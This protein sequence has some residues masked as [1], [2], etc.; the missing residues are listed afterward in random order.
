MSDQKNLIIAIALS[1]AIMLGFQFFVDAP[2][3]ERMRAEQA[4]QKA[5]T[6]QVTTPDG[7]SAPTAAGQVPGQAPGLSAMPSV[8]GAPVVPGAA[9][10]AVVN[11]TPRVTIDGKRLR[12][13]INLVG[14]RIDDVILP[15]YKETLAPD[16]PAIT[17]LSPA[18]SPHAY[19]AEFGWT[20][21]PGDTTK[22]PGGQT[23]WT[24]D[25]EVLKPGET[26]NLRWDNGEGVVFT[27]EIGRAHV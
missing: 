25:R 9:R 23:R 27:R 14:G 2:R 21:A 16:S 15:D 5:A 6:T 19:Y 1:L 13:S 22:L 17:L 7:S 3:Q 8:P 4:A 24:A 18:G 20:A 26:L 10:E 12:G 11:Q